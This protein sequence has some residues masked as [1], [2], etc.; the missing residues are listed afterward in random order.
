VGVCKGVMVPVVVRVVVGMVVTVSVIE[1]LGWV[2][3]VC[4]LLPV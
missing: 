4:E 2:L 3:G 1:A